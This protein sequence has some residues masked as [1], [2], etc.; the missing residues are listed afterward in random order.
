ML[1]GK[2]EPILPKMN[3]ERIRAACE[4]LRRNPWTPALLECSSTCPA[5][6]FPF[7]FLVAKPYPLRFR[8]PES[9][10]SAPNSPLP[11]TISPRRLTHHRYDIAGNRTV[12]PA[13]YFHGKQE[14]MHFGAVLAVSFTAVACI[15]TVNVAGLASTNKLRNDL[16][17]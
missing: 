15:G 5:T 9:G 12:A 14:Q 2:C 11:T 7:R 10:R 17:L 4:L 16:R 8:H 3:L 13:I 6:L 1:T